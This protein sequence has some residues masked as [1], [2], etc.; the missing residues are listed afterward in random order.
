M[1]PTV[2]SND[3][4]YISKNTGEEISYAKF[5]FIKTSNDIPVTI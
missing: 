2:F 3:N 4:K 5:V 1:K